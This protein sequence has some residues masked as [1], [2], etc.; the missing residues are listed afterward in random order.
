MK[1][2][3]YTL[4]LVTDST[5]LPEGKTLISQ[6]A[7]GLKNGVTIV[8][9]RE[10]DTDA[11]TFVALALEA[12]KLCDHYNVP[13]IIND[14]VDIALAID[15]SGIHVGQ[16]DI[17]IPM[18][19][20]LVG[21]EKI[22][23]WS[24]GKVEEV[25]QL[26]EWGPGMINYIG[27]GTVFDTQTKKDS[28]KIP[29]GP[30]GVS[31]ILTRLQEKKCDWIKTV[32][33]GG[34]H[35]DNISRVVYQSQ[36]LDGKRSIDGISLV[37]DIMASDDAGQS[38]RIL[39]EIL[40]EKSHHFFEGGAADKNTANIKEN[41]QKLSPLIHHITNRVHQNFGA[42]VALAIGCSPIMSEVA[43]E[44]EDLCKIPH[45]VLLLNTGTV[46]DVG[47]LI[48]AVKTYNSQ[49]RPIVLDPVGFSASSARLI[50]NKKVLSAGQFACI[51]GNTGEIM[52]V[53]GL[54]GAMKGVD[55]SGDDSL[56]TRIEATQLVAFKY[57][58]VAVCTGEIDIV[59][60]GTASLK[61]PLQSGVGVSSADLSYELI[62]SEN[63]PLFGRITASGCSLGTV[64]A[65][66]VCAA[67][68]ESIFTAVVQAVTLYKLAGTRANAT[69]KGSG[70]FLV[71]LIDNLY[72]AAE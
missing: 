60:D 71:D 28:K 43:A 8:Q 2:A 4:Y 10:K 67:N 6:L 39:R 26:A 50:L 31:R 48:H 55:S 63:V 58:T 64:I 70:S 66:F 61:R 22:V 59:V 37:S 20:K 24:V 16:D 38:T 46:A 30:E 34:L 65:G 33:I 51:K 72:L 35:P 19:R 40:A 13:L 7:E 21:P 11:K 36:S 5:M 23:G 1:A 12:K 53:S 42:N 41:V 54:G 47:I 49:K 18:V 69:C 3:D 17:P 25:D 62:K 32:A 14:R 29:M 45:S 56:E 27:V 9:L 44:F 57:R 15:A 68:D 52:G